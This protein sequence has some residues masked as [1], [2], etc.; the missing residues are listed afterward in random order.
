[1]TASDLIKTFLASLFYQS[2]AGFAPINELEPV[3]VFRYISALS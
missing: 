1:M 2:E 3:L